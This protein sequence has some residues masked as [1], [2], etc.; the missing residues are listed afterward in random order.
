VTYVL[1]ATTQ[2][3]IGLAIA[4]VAVLGWLIYIF[5]TTHRSA[6]P[7]SEVELAP[8]RRP[9]LE[10]SALEGPRLDRFL[11]WALV[12]L[13][14]LAVGLPA[15]W[16][17]E[18]SRQAGAIRGFDKRA[19]ERGHDLFTPA[20]PPSDPGSRK[21]HFACS[22]CHG[23]EGQGGA[24]TYSLP[25]TS[26]PR[27]VQWQCPPLN[28]VM[29]RYHQDAD[30]TKPN[31]EVRNIIVYGRQ[32]TPMPAWG[33]AGG[34]PMNDQQIS[35]LIAYL[36][37]IQITPEQAMAQAAPLGTNGKAL[38]DGYCARCHT[39]GFSYG[40][41]GVAGG[42]AFGPNL[43][44][45]D[46]LRQFPDPAL[47][48]QWVSQTAELGKAYGVRGVSHGIMPHFGEML[49]PEQIKAVVDYERSL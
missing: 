9:Y 8:N 6:E 33:L 34:G 49:T 2:Q 42:G 16:L 14:V 19:I 20:P 23:P 44:N 39:Q 1:A 46:T 36:T 10:D 3:K 32:N 30:R 12:F 22:T 15:Y 28:T 25:G 11:I 38:F 26:P 48:I 18:P 40:E 17:R 45:G 21:P 41:P 35:D 7:G 31:Q 37:S 47:Q 43:T 29:L 24:T 13:A 4:I 5:T 27:Q